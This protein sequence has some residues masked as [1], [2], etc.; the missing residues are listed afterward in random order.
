VA[1]LQWT[2]RGITITA[3]TEGAIL[4]G[5]LSKQSE[6]V[7]ALIESQ[8]RAYDFVL[9]FVTQKQPARTFHTTAR[10]MRE[11]YV[12]GSELA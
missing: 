9:D 12:G 1:T 4:G 10:C 6:H 3:A 8:L 5:L 7:R 11:G 2:Y